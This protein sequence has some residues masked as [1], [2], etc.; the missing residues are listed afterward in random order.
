MTITP[1]LFR[2]RGGRVERGDRL[3]FAVERDAVRWTVSS[4]CPGAGERS[5]QIGAVTPAARWRSAF[6]NRDSPSATAP[7]SSMAR[8]TSGEPHVT[9]VTATTSMP[10]SA[11]TTARVLAVIFAR[12]ML[13]VA[14]PVT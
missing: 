8:P 11:D 7:P 1:C 5:S 2:A 4:A 14:A 12:S 3:E 13:R 6:C 10:P 9:F